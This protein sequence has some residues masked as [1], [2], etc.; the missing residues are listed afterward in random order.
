M[1]QV[2]VLHPGRRVAFTVTSKAWRELGALADQPIFVA[3]GS[4]NTGGGG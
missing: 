2:L 4:A 3:P 1:R